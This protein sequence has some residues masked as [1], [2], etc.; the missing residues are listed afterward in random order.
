MRKIVLNL[1]VTLDGFIEGPNGEI[2]WLSTGHSDTGMESHFDEFLAGIDTIFYG[3]ISYEKWGEFQ[4]DDNAANWEK[5]LW[6]GV[7]SK[8]KVVFSKSMERADGK[9]EVVG[10]D[11]PDRV[12][13]IKAE[14]GKDIWLYGGASLTTSFMNLGLVDRFLLAVFPVILGSGKPLFADIRNRTDLH[15]KDVTRDSGII[16]LDYERRE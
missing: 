10:S 6:E 7:H 2:D 13:D 16:L 11:I 1:A 9:V 12:Q 3:R 15:L 14:A 4:P 5:K 8:R